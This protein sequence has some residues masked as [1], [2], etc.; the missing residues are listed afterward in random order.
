MQPYLAAVWRARSASRAAAL[1]PARGTHSIKLS[2]TPTGC[3]TSENKSLAV[4]QAEIVN[5]VGE[6]GA[7]PARLALDQIHPVF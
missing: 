1:Q 5:Q 3:I 6:R 4:V 7:R 2:S